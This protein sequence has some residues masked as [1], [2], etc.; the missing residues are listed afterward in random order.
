MDKYSELLM[1]I[2]LF[3]GIA[4][5]NIPT[6]LKN[7]EAYTRTYHKN[8]YIRL[9]GDPADFI[10]IVLSGNIQILQH[11]YYGNRSI[12]AS[13]GTGSLFGEAFACAGIPILPVDI[14][15]GEDTT[16]MFM[17][18]SRI[19]SPCGGSCT[20][21][22]TLI[23]NLLTIVASKNMMLNQKL[24][25]ISHRTTAEKL[26]AYLND[27]AKLHASAEFTIPFDRQELADYL[28]V[29]RSA[30]CAEISKLVKAGILETRRSYF[31]LIAQ[32]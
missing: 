6:L 23:G 18:R 7:L 5:E 9:S 14:L 21:H 27:Q 3:A 26:L 24:Q 12:T 13:F 30:M 17:N 25:Y 1:T 11:D 19:L 16:I 28:G 10:G 2:P 8:E 4:G 20:F 15:S 32:D 29:E 31:R 22:H